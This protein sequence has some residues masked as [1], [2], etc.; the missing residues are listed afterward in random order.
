MQ[1][2]KENFYIYINC[3]LCIISVSFPQQKSEL[4]R[5]KTQ[6]VA[7]FITLIS[8]LDL[9]GKNLQVCHQ[10]AWGSW[11]NRK[12]NRWGQDTKIPSLPRKTNMAGNG[13]W[14]KWY[15]YIHIYSLA[16]N[17][18]FNQRFGDKPAEHNRFPGTFAVND[19]NFQEITVDSQRSDSLVASRPGEHNKRINLDCKVLQGSLY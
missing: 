7:I 19:L 5:N 18:K 3:E 6:G 17:K 15:M 8:H 4:F 1:P 13:T 9:V 10:I 14:Y 12:K 16:I 11:R 2:W